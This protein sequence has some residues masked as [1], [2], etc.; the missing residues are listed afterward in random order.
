MTEVQDVYWKKEENSN[1]L[2]SQLRV[3]LD[4]TT[5]K[6]EVSGNF[7]ISPSSFFLYNITQILSSKSKFWKQYLCFDIHPQL[8]SVTVINK[9]I[10]L[11]CL[12]LIPFIPPASSIAQKK[13][14]LF[15]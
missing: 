8:V 7:E 14:L 2:P 1:F 4:I 10:H 6:V 12:L 9:I 5:K 3:I 13:S 11:Y 15:A